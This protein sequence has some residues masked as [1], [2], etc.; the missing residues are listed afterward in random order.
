M[1]AHWMMKILDTCATT[2]IE[3]LPLELFP[4]WP[5][6]LGISALLWIFI[7]VVTFYRYHFCNK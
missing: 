7:Y 6:P 1:L 5:L 2:R 4:S 3:N